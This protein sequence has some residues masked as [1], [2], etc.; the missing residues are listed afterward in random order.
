MD[1]DFVF[2]RMMDYIIRNDLNEAKA[3]A[4]SDMNKMN[5]NYS[6][7]IIIIMNARTKTELIKVMAGFTIMSDKVKEYYNN[8]QK[9][10]I[11][12]SK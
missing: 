8:P 6:S 4:I 12:Y 5:D 7:Y 10:I 9:A 2:E 1:P 3:S 11:D